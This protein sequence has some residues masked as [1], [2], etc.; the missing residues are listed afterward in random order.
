MV[1][2]V[3][4][5]TSSTREYYIRDLPLYKHNFFAVAL[6]WIAEFK[7]LRVV[8]QSNLSCILGS[9]TEKGRPY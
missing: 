4:R 7:D 1:D 5:S 6:E 2:V 3:L 9:S 8:L